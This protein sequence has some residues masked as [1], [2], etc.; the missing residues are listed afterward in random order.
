MGTNIDRW[1]ER[2]NDG[3]ICGVVQIMSHK[4]SR[5]G[6]SP[7]GQPLGVIQSGAFLIILILAE[8][9]LEPDKVILPRGPPPTP[10]QDRGGTPWVVSC[11]SRDQLVST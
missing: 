10:F 9:G 6:V 11:W 7:N 2:F 3:L 5:N 1:G 4:L 8:E